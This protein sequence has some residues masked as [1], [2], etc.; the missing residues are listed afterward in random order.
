MSRGDEG[1]ESAEPLLRQVIRRYVA[2]RSVAQLEREAGLQAGAIA[3]YLKPS[4]RD[5]YRRTSPDL[6]LKIAEAIG[7]PLAE[8]SEAALADAG[9][10]AG[11]SA[12]ADVVLTDAEAALV[13]D[14]R[15]LSPE[16]QRLA[17]DVLADF[18][19]LPAVPQRIV[20]E[21]VAGARRAGD[22]GA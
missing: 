5:K 1:R 8:L 6:L 21:M 16:G 18:R 17:R 22:S 20:R 11:E 3:Y 15:A 14:F 13:A 9:F 4:T 19:D 12:K 7:A 10:A 2:G